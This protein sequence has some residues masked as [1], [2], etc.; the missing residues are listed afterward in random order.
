M[1]TVF[2]AVPIANQKEWLDTYWNLNEYVCPQSNRVVAEDKEYVL[3]SVVTFR[4]VLEEFK[5]ACRKRRYVIREVDTG[6][7][8]SHVELKQLQEKAEKDK[9]TFYTLLWQQYCVCYVAWI[10]LKSIRVFVE[11]LLKYGLPPRFI[12]VVVQLPASKEAEV[13]KRIS[14]IYPDLST[15]LA[16]DTFYDNGALQQEYPYISLKVANVQV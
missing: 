9:K 3:N 15:P 1:V 7:D 2:V 10:H 12:S 14:E 13:R 16:H 11:S 4:K 5:T 8:L 6:D